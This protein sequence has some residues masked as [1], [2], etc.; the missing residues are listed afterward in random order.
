MDYKKILGKVGG[1]LAIVGF[2]LMFNFGI[3]YMNLIAFILIAIGTCMISQSSTRKATAVASFIFSGFAL[4]FNVWM[5]INFI[6]LEP[7]HLY[8]PILSLVFN[9]LIV[10]LG[11]L[12]LF[13]KKAS[14][15][16]K[17]KNPLIKKLIELEQK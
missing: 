2:I 15:E 3:W 6:T 4:I 5:L 10:G 9:L 11:V 7:N 12:N 13:L 16:G 8:A 14:E 1:L 17:E